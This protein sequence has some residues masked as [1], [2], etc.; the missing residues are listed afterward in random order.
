MAAIV[1][2]IRAIVIERQNIFSKEQENVRLFRL[3]NRLH[4]RTKET[5]IRRELLLKPGE[6]YDSALA[7]ETER[8]LRGLGIFGSVS[9]TPHWVSD[10]LR[11]LLIETT[12]QWTTEGS[13]AF[14]GG[15]GAYKFSLGVEE[16]NFLGWGQKL[17]LAYEESDVQVSR[18]GSFYDRKLMSLPL[19]LS[20]TGEDRSDGY[21]YSIETGRPLYSSRDTWGVNLQLL[22]SSGRLRFF[23]DGEELF[24]FQQTTKEAGFSVLRSWGRE[25]KTNASIEYLLDQNQVEGDTATI[26]LARKLYGYVLPEERVHAFVAGANW[27]ANRYTEE[28][29][30][31]NFG[32]VEEIR[33]GWSAY[34]EYVLAP[35]FLGSSVTRHEAAFSLGTTHKA[36]LQFFRLLV[37]N[38]TTFLSQRWEGTFWQGGVRSY[39]QWGER[40]TAAFRLDIASLSGV[41]RYGQF[42]LGGESGLRGYE[43]RKFSGSRMVLGTLEQRLFGPNLFSLLGVGGVF[44]IDFG[45]TWKSRENF[46]LREIKSDWGVGLRLG[47]VKFP[48]FKV[49]RFDWA[50]PFGPGRWVFSFGTGMSF[51]LE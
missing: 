51:K 25:F 19:S 49:L 40:R 32:N 17:E 42:L 24:A 39:W 45:D 47:L 48:D 38:R 23:E 15:G 30:L 41:S 10:S 11:D 6:N 36:G 18:R 26:R 13:L 44:F 5:V 1:P 12:D 3:A 16:K 50:R 20:L 37:G 2:K 4:L 35:R 34:F 27:Y 33:K 46:Q 14:G 22:S 7:E 28:K 29:Y 21:Y 9:V 8:N 31:D 43:A